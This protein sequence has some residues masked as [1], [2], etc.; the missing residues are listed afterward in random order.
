[1]S[2]LRHKVSRDPLP[3]DCR[4]LL[5]HIGLAQ[6]TDLKH[7]KLTG[8]SDTSVTLTVKSLKP[9]LTITVTAQLTDSV[10]DLKSLVAKSSS[11]APAV[12]TQRLL[13]KG[14][15][16]SD[17]KLLKEYD[18]VDGATIHLLLKP[19]DKA[20]PGPSSSPAL[21]P[22]PSQSSA[23]M[24]A[25]TFTPTSTHP[26]PPALT[27]TTSLDDSHSTSMPLTIT[28]A[29]APPLGPQPQVSS[30]AFHQ[31]IS[32]PAFWQKIH[33]L[34]VSEFTY[35]NDADQTWET[36]LVA[37]KGKLSAGEAAKIRDVVGVRGKSVARLGFRWASGADADRRLGMGGA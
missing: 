37:M 22:A 33:A 25:S 21:A 30:A 1:M 31:T 9:S 2:T 34:C 35:E 13:V 5:D 36:F 26:D 11:T 32:D 8:P 20:H 15:T 4:K 3:L 12:D 28:D 10:A 19:A 27:I 18:L 6:A 29:V 7:L 17:T 16:L 14:K 24:S 23:G